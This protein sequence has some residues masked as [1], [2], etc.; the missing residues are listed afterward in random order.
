VCFYAPQCICSRAV[1]D[2]MKDVSVLY[3]YVTFDHKPLFI[4]FDQ[5]LCL[6]SVNPLLR[7]VMD[8]QVK[9]DWAKADA[10]HLALYAAH[11]TS[12]LSEVSIPDCKD[13]SAI[14]SGQND[15]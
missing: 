15:Y 7:P 14:N 1:D 12:L 10:G 3:D 5:V 9:P 8:K 2:Y 11:L 4:E 13:G 6:S